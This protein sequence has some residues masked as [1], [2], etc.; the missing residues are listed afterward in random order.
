LAQGFDRTEAIK[1]GFA[2]LAIAPIM[3][4]T[5]HSNPVSP[6]ANAE[7]PENRASAESQGCGVATGL[8]DF[9]G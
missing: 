3:P 6:P 4:R 7:N 1:I 8:L 5:Q 2:R 9:G